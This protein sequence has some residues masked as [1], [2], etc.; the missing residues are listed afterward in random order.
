MAE[1]NA[2]TVE[3]SLPTRLSKL[4][5]SIFF[6]VITSIEEALL[7]LAGRQI[8]GRCVTLYY[9]CVSPRQRAGFAR[10]MD[11]LLKQA[12]PVTVARREPLALGKRYAA[13]TFD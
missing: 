11:V 10:Q 4:L 7:R 12:V 5:I 13:V 1:T 2:E 8:A 6:F 3:Q 9:H